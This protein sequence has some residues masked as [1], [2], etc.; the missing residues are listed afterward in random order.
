MGIFTTEVLSNICHLS[1]CVFAF[2]IGVLC[3]TSVLL[4]FLAFVIPNAFVN[5]LVLLASWLDLQ[6][7]TFLLSLAL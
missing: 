3:S 5:I 1:I 7:I 6:D 2:D 4:N